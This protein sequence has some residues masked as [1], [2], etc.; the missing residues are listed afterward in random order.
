MA[1]AKT[2]RKKVASPLRQTIAN[3]VAARA[4]VQF[5]D[6]PN[7]PMAIREASH[8]SEAERIAKSTVQRIMAAQTSATLEQ[9]EGLA[10]ALQLA[11]YQLLMPNLD[12]TNP[13]VAR[14]AVVGEEQVYAIAERAVKDAVET[15]FKTHG[16]PHER[17]RRS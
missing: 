11:P 13:Q 2:R 10:R 16:R 14:G 1:K 5:R 7:V 17:I 9:I 15:A 6:K 8:P 3:N 12:P 4:A